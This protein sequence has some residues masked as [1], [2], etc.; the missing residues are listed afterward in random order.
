MLLDRHRFAGEGRLVGGEEIPL[1]ELH[2]GG[3]DI[4]VPDPDDI[5]GDEV[6]G[7][8]LLPLP[9]AEHPRLER[10]LL[11]EH[12]DGVPCLILLPETDDRVDDEEGKYDPEVL[13]APDDGGYDDRRLDHPGDRAPEIAEELQDCALLLL[14]DLVWAELLNT[15]FGLRPGEAALLRRKGLI[16]VVN[17]HPPGLISA[18][19]LAFH[20]YSRLPL[21]PGSYI[22]AATDRQV[23]AGSYG[24]RGDPPPWWRGI[25]SA[26][27]RW[28]RQQRPT[29]WRSAGGPTISQLNSAEIRSSMERRS[30]TS[31]WR[32]VL[33][34]TYRP[35]AAASEC[36]PGMSSDRAPTFSYRWLR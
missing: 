26:G 11:F 21:I 32:S 4:P 12:G 22:R 5:A 2:I 10:K 31:L 6:P 20:Q 3:D 16:E 7:S 14:G 1:D 8:D 29:R 24:S 9:I 33:R 25:R 34:A 28:T 35:I 19:R 23:S 36:S 15:V 17:G 30:P 27:C 13:P 18:D